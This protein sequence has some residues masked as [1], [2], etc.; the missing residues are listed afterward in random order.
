MLELLFISTTVSDS[1]VIFLAL[2]ITFVNCRFQFQAVPQISTNRIQDLL[3]MIRE[4]S[5][6]TKKLWCKGLYIDGKLLQN[7]HNSSKMLRFPLERHY[8]YCAMKIKP[9][10]PPQKEYE[11]LRRK[12]S[13]IKSQKTRK[14]LRKSFFDAL[15][16][17]YKDNLKAK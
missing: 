10:P 17:E 1:A 13:P 14:A 8:W 4:T 11:F 5:W 3:I 16:D 12:Y 9:P 6:F 15:Q 7:G 2:F